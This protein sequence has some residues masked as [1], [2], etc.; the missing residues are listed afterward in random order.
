MLLLARFQTNV[1]PFILW[2][3]TNVDNIKRILPGY[4]RVGDS[5]C[6]LEANVRVWRPRLRRG[7]LKYLTESSVTV[8][9]GTPGASRGKVP[10]WGQQTVRI[11]AGRQN[12]PGAP[13]VTQFND[14]VRRRPDRSRSNRESR[15]RARVERNVAGREAGSGVCHG[16]GH[17]TPRPSTTEHG[18][19][20]RECSPGITDEGKVLI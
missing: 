14:R 4:V 2:K 9:A 13:A 15:R 5:Q 6:L 16:I 1:D 20:R 7:T 17:C 8:C 10:V 12:T 11:L 18:L 19:L 3:A